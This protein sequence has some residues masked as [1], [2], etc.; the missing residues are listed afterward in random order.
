MAGWALQFTVWAHVAFLRG[1]E[2]VTATRMAS[3]VRAIVTVRASDD[4]ERIT[5][6]WRCEIGGRIYD[7]KED[8]RP[9]QERRMLAMLAEP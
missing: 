8:P 5:S 6:E 1:S 4:A 3:K 2:T 7:I 9:D